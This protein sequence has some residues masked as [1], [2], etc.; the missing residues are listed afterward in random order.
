M[1]FPLAA[2]TAELTKAMFSKKTVVVFSTKQKTG[3]LLFSF[4]QDMFP[5]LSSN[6]YITLCFLPEVGVAK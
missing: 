2:F 1:L 4:Y 6:S 3:L 5:P